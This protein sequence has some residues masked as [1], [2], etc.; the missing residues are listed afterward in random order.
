MEALE[1]LRERKRMCNVCEWCHKCPLD[2]SI[3][4]CGIDMTD[5]NYQRV[6]NIVE[7]WSKEQT[8]KTRNDKFLE[9]F[10]NASLIALGTLGICPKSLDK[11]Y[12]CIYH[13]NCD[14]TKFVD[15]IGCK[16]NFWLEEVE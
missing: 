11:E 1:F 14:G 12:E 8:R 5:E 6:I 3:C 10:P 9:M 7:K 16:N 13:L 4:N 2:P 15:C